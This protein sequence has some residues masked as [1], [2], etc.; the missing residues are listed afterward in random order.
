MKPYIRRTRRG[1]DDGVDLLDT[2]LLHSKGHEI[3]EASTQT[4]NQSPMTTTA[5]SLSDLTRAPLPAS[6]TDSTLVLSSTKLGAP[7]TERTMACSRFRALQRH[8]RKHWAV[9]RGMLT[10]LL[11]LR[12]IH[13]NK[14]H[15]MGIEH[16]KCRCIEMTSHSGCPHPENADLLKMGASPM[17]SK[18]AACMSELLTRA[19]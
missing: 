17:G 8:L 16:E 5:R 18:Q 4:I 7:W 9:M 6:A 12:W 13:R 2:H 3:I 10:I 19:R 11:S 1:V 14:D 15:L